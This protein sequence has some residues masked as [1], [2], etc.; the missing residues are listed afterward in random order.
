M[1][2]RSGR[3]YKR[4]RVVRRLLDVIAR[5]RHFRGH[6]VHS[7]YVYNIVREVFMRQRLI[8]SGE[9]KLYDLLK[10]RVDNDVA[11]Q[12]QNL[13]TVCGYKEF[14]IDNVIS[15]DV[16]LAIYSLTYPIERVG[17]S[18]IIARESGTT[19]VIFT[20]DR[21]ADFD[22]LTKALDMNHKSTIIKKKAYLLIFNNHLPKQRYTL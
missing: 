17:E 11:I 9:F 13:A 8:V 6:G 3:A 21:D 5:I 16:D 4:Y 22:E 20:R 14:V 15:T 18:L 1:D 7:P 2:R 10:S 19:V 12:L